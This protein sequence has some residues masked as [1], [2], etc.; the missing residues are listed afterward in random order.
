MHSPFTFQFILQVLNNGQGYHPP[1]AIGALH[2][3]LLA[4]DRLLE[5]LDLGAGS[6]AG[7]VKKLSVQKVARTAV[8]PS[9]YRNMLYRLVCY[10]KPAH[11][12]ELGTSLGVTTATLALAN[13]TARVF[14]IEGNP[15]IA[16]IAQEGFQ[17]LGL[18]NVHAFR[19]NF[20]SVLPTVL[21]QAGRLDLALVDGN[22]RYEPTL[23]YF[24]QLLEKSHNDTILVFDDIHWSA[25]ME[26]A[27]AQIKAHPAVRC[28]VDIFFM[29]FVFLRSEFKV[30]QHFTVRF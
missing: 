26:Q 14:T 27:W 17:S 13:P 18:S 3:V 25:E 29:G 28:T 30:P 16:G 8:M 6:R 4:D 15:S 12:L 2:K 24:K 10:Y 21:A 7:T 9:R 22:H 11:I 23:R 1:H 5:P 19:G 20:D